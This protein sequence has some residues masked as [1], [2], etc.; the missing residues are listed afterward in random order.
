VAWTSRASYQGIPLLR[1]E[2]RRSDGLRP[3]PGWADV[4]LED[5]GGALEVD[6]KGL[7]WSGIN[8][9]FEIPGQISI[10]GWSQIVFPSISF[11]VKEQ[12]KAPEQG[13]NH[14]GTLF[15]ETVGHQGELISP[16]LLYNWVYVDSAGIEEYGPQIAEAK[17]HDRGQI[18]IPLT[19]IRRYYRD[20]GL[21]MTRINVRDE[22]GIWD[23]ATLVVGPGGTLRPWTL[24]EVVRYLF[25]LLPGCPFATFDEELAKDEKLLNTAPTGIIGRG[26]PAVEHLERLLET[27]RIV[28]KMQPG[29]NYSLAR[30]G[31]TL[32]DYGEVPTD[33]GAYTRYENLHY[34]TRSQYCTD[35]ALMY[36]VVGKPKVRRITL[37]YVPVLEDD[38]G[39][40]FPLERCEEVLG[41]PLAALNRHV[42]GTGDRQFADIIRP[43]DDDEAR[44]LHERQMKMLQRMAYK[45]YVPSTAFSGQV[46][47]TATGGVPAVSQS[48]LGRQ[49]FLPL[50]DCAWKKT[51]IENLGVKVPI[52]DLGLGDEEPIAV[53]PPVVRAKRTGEGWFQDFPAVERHYRS[54]LKPRLDAI[55]ALR[56]MLGYYGSLA[57]ALK[58]KTEVEGIDGNRINT[59]SAEGPV[60]SL[61]KTI[62]NSANLVTEK[63]RTVQEDAE[64]D[65]KAAASLR[66]AFDKGEM[67]DALSTNAWERLA[68][69]Q[70]VADAQEA[71]QKELLAEESARITLEEE[72]AKARTS[73]GRRKGL[74]LKMNLPWAVIDGAESWIDKRTGILTSPIPLCWATKPFWFQG[75]GLAVGSSGSVVVTAG[76]EVYDTWTGGLTT[77][78]FTVASDPPEPIYCGMNRPSALKGKRIE[79]PKLRLYQND[80]GIPLNGAAVRN[81]AYDLVLGEAG[82]PVSVTGYTYTL[83]GLVR[84]VLYGGVN[85]IQHRFDAEHPAR[86]LTWV[87][88]NAPGARGPIMGQARPVRI[89]M[90][91]IR[92]DSVDPLR[93]VQ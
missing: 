61:R 33:P 62:V 41:Y 34:E 65:F 64:A 60:A 21:L 22:R 16:P 10:W 19:D 30:K 1:L 6:F 11:D 84:A 26:E 8:D 69:A 44:S 70:A 29:G 37:L 71:V 48:L 14:W 67:L 59:V 43:D 77:V 57:D 52:S 91:P 90:G 42:F 58:A 75:E 38:D 24:S 2:Y 36:T 63:G 79:A 12:A 4:L 86:N 76:Y 93:E 49:P 47:T 28:A 15:I 25:N 92:L 78:L 13:L 81:D 50:V 74:P 18:R 68:L 3:E 82:Q 7:P 46:S 87:A 53:L 51:E 85:S 88:V 9:D 31:S 20:Y 45:V 39:M 27:Y 83:N 54:L 66:L 89:A 73:F 5:I 80:L 56:E 23:P 17:N 55:D 40:L 35:R 72:L 32:G